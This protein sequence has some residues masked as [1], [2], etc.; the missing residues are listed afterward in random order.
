M[1][2]VML[3]I[4]ALSSLCVGCAEGKSAGLSKDQIAQIGDICDYSAVLV[5]SNGRVAAEYDP[6]FSEA[7]FSYRESFQI[8]QKG[9]E[10]EVGMFYESIAPGRIDFQFLGCLTTGEAKSLIDQ[11]NSFAVDQK[12]QISTKHGLLQHG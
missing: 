7:I 6:E 9:R 10:K 8:G 5:D 3:F 11:F 1:K 2:Y 4:F 12:Y